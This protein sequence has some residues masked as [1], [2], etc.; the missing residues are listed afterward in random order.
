M[1][2]NITRREY[3]I[4]DLQQIDAILAKA[5]IIHIGMV[6]DGY[7]YVVPM[8]YGYTFENGKLT[9]YL[10]GAKTGKKLDVLRQNPNIFFSIES[11]T[12]SFEGSIACR[13]GMAYNSVLGK[14]VATLVED[15]EDKKRALTI[16]MKSQTGK[17]FEI[18][19]KM[20]SIVSII[21]I[22]VEEYTA[23]SRPAPANP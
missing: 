7:P 18:T 16:L 4:T 13:Y 1:N 3:E 6:D 2:K 9:F 11:D 15:V 5:K 20:V 14:G 22:D 10:H 21:R 19:D 12:Q 8:N 23:K 17:D